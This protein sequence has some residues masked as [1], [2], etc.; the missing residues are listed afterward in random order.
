MTSA[1]LRRV[2]GARESYIQQ[3]DLRREL[4]AYKTQDDL[5]DIEAAL[6]RHNYDETEHIRRILAAQRAALA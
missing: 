6:D 1:I 5:N 4:S 2:R 3:R